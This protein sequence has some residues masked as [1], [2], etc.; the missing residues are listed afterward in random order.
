[1]SVYTQLQ[2]DEVTTFLAR[3]GNLKLL[4]LEATT[5]GIE[6]SNYFLEVAQAA[7]HT[8]QNDRDSLETNTTNRSLVLTVFESVNERDLPYFANLLTHLQQADL[9]VPAPLLDHQGNFLQFLHNKP[10]MVVPRLPGKHIQTPNIA[11]CRAIG[12]ALAELHAASKGFSLHRQGDFNGEWR[13][14]SAARVQPLLD[15]NDTSLLQREIARWQKREI[16][17]PE[18]PRG[19]THG[20]LFHDNA[21]FEGNQ[22]TGIIDFYYACNDVF[23]YDIAIVMNDWCIHDDGT[24]DEARYSAV[25]SGYQEIRPL[26]AIEIA[27]L[28]EYLVFAA[29]R[30]W[31]S[32][33]VNNCDPAKAGVQQKSPAPMKALLLQRLREFLQ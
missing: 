33:L 3:Y 10:C 22:L 4:R 11:Q 24:L 5:S 29:L 8:G 32:R 9:P 1:M 12:K 18:L 17:G 21:L 2:F 26:Q 28:P 14:Q 13:K 31:L 25:L 7:Q 20:D 6:N 16:A 23:V 15:A 30:F 19:V 27:A